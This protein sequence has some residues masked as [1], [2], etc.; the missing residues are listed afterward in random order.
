[1]HFPVNLFTSDIVWRAHEV[2]PKRRKKNKNKKNDIQPNSI[3]IYIYIERMKI[4][5]GWGDD[6]D[7]D[8]HFTLIKVNILKLRVHTA[9]R[10]GE[11][12]FRTI[13]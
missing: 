6:D 4:E 10:G 1:M 12:I 13:K 2:K 7:D 9:L 8:K 3:Q 11:K 5:C